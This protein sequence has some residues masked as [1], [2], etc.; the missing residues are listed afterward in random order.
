MPSSKAAKAATGRTDWATLRAMSEDE[1]ERIAA[2]DEENPA[3]DEDY[4]ANANIYAPANKIVIHATFDKE[5]VEFFQRGGADYSARMNAVL[6]SY[7]EAQQSEK[8]KR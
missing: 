2:E 6:R 7:V 3:T 4:W 1:I 8:P 5:V